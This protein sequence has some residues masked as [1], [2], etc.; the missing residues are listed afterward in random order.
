MPHHLEQT[1]FVLGRYPLAIGP[2]VELELF[3][4]LAHV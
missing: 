4:E 1:L 2:L 3:A